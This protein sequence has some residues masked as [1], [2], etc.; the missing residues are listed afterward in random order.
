M[1]DISLKDLA[2]SFEVETLKGD[3]PH[4]FARVHN[5]FYEGVK[6]SFYKYINISKQDYDLIPLNG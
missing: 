5:L 2:I 1:L 4:L 3:F 6:P